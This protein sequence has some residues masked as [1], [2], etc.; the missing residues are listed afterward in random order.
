[1]LGGAV[2][3]SKTLSAAL[4][5]ANALTAKPELDKSANKRKL[6]ERRLVLN[7]CIKKLKKK[8]NMTLTLY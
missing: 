2:L 8:K 6:K 4:N 3:A 5:L 1:M 7:G